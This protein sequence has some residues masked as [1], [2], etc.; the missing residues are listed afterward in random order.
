MHHPPRPLPLPRP[1]T[2]PRRLPLFRWAA[3]ALVSLTLA[4]ASAVRVDASSAPEKIVPLLPGAEGN[5]TVETITF[6]DADE[7]SGSDSVVA[8][9]P[10]TGGGLRL[11][12]KINGYGGIVLRGGDLDIARL[13]ALRSRVRQVEGEPA[14]LSLQFTSR[15]GERV[16]F[17]VDAIPAGA[18]DDEIRVTPFGHFT[19]FNAPLLAD[20]RQVALVLSA[21][22]GAIE[23]DTLELVTG[24]EIPVSALPPHPA[25]SKVPLPPGL[26]AWTYGSPR[27]VAGE[28]A[29]YNK[30]VPA[31]RRLR[32]LFQHSG[33]IDIPSGGIPRFRWNAGRAAAL[34]EALRAVGQKEV[35]VL[36]MIDGLTANVSRVPDAEWRR[37]AGE[38]GAVIE[39]DPESFGVHFDLEPHDPHVYLL[40]SYMRDFTAKPVTAAV[41]HSSPD[42]FRYTDMAVLMGY[43]YARTPADFRAAIS[44]KVADF[45]A[46]AREGRGL[47]MIGLPAIATH[48]EMEAVADT[49]HGPRTATGFTMSEFVETGLDATEAGLR[50]APA[51]HG[52]FSGYAIW[53]IHEP[54]ALHAPSDTHHYFPGHVAPEVWRLFEKRGRP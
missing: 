3:S 37:L 25:K 6:S 13:A 41:A 43:D 48:H 36:P 29:R 31:D 39:P 51:A 26:G 5:P 27:F 30:S 47:A 14:R 20:A 15:A 4:M 12:Y 40:F 9:E 54:E 49:L 42:L 2:R 44:A 45:L 34:R 7:V 28:V 17:P 8:A 19:A 21:G 10:I 35:R 32:Y 50:R 33:T 1:D 53:A 38:I 11:R 24:G 23:I 46:H 18:A 22:V 52:H 16:Y